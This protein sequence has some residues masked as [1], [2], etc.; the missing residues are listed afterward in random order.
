MLMLRFIVLM[1]AAAGAGMVK[2][3]A[4][5]RILEPAPFGCYVSVMGVGVFGGILLSAGGVEAATKSFPRY[6]DS[7]ATARIRAEI[8]RLSTALVFRCLAVLAAVVLVAAFCI[9]LHQISL[10]VLAVVYAGSAAVVN[11]VAAGLRSVNHPMMLASASLW[12]SLAMLAAGLIGSWL[13]GWQGACLADVAVMVAWILACR[14][15]LDRILPRNGPDEERRRSDGGAIALYVSGLLFAA[16]SM[17]DRA[18]ITIVAGPAIAGSYGLL[19]ILP[20][21][22]QLLINARAQKIGPDLIRMESETRSSVRRRMLVFEISMLAI[23][24]SGAGF[25]ALLLKEAGLIDR[26]FRSYDIS[27]RAILLATVAAFAQ[28]CGHLEFHLIA[29]DR[30][31]QILAASI[32]SV[33]VLAVSLGVVAIVGPSLERVLVAA[34]LARGVYSLW[35]GLIAW[36]PRTGGFSS[37]GENGR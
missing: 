7:G 28:I 27:G 26:Y 14:R 10:V 4:I 15:A 8:D 11:L 37:G 35:L 24:C 17:L 1:A 32:T 25:V 23:F 20:Q 34:V 12:R 18:A 21:S 30:E 36:Q 31:R 33:F 29:L 22:A 16:L 2:M 5:A 9:D 3:L 19:G 13:G 6:W